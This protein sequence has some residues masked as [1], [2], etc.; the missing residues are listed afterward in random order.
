M[1][2]HTITRAPFAKT[3]HQFSPGRLNRPAPAPALSIP[4]GRFPHS[5]LVCVLTFAHAIRWASC[6][7][8]PTRMW[9][10]GCGLPCGMT[11]RTESVRC[12]HLQSPLTRTD[13]PVFSIARHLAIPILVQHILLLC[14]EVGVGCGGGAFFFRVGSPRN[15]QYG[16]HRPN[17]FAGSLMAH[18]GN[19]RLNWW[20]F[21]APLSI[22]GFQII[23]FAF[24][25]Y[26]G[27][28]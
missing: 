16:H 13:T 22:C 10:G 7:A 27:G 25:F 26:S 3:Q 28:N 19:I 4:P 6:L 11:R 20:S 23:V 12:D 5:S 15:S 1:R 2:D 14:F 18:I 24:I 9:C 8:R 17:G 21:D